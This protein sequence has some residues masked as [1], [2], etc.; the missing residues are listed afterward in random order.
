M[1]SADDAGEADQAAAARQGHRP[2]AL[3]E[4]VAEE[5]ADRHEQREGAEA[6][7]GQLQAEIRTS[8]REQHRAPVEAGSL[9]DQHA[10]AEGAERQQAERR[11]RDARQTLALARNGRRRLRKPASAMATRDR[12]GRRPP[13]MIMCACGVM[14]AP[15]KPAPISPPA[16]RPTLQKPWQ[17]LMIRR[18]RPRSM[19][20]A[21]TFIATSTTGCARPTT[22]SPANR[23]GNAPG[24]IP[25]GN[26]RNSRRQS[27][28]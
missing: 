26:R 22:K 4:T 14:P 5:T 12:Q 23:L 27:R 24:S 10:E 16:I 6:D 21:S 20:S 11:Q 3:G 2:E 15:A 1:T 8:S 28:R 17:V 9:D 13:T 19:R 7:A 18:P 25:A